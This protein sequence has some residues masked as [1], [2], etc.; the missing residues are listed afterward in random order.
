MT[1][2][3][4]LVIGNWKMNMLASQAKD[5]ARSL[6]D[7]FS[8]VEDVEVVIAPPYTSLY[9]VSRV[10]KDSPIGLAGQ[11]FYH[12]SNGAYTGEVALEM[13]TD[14]GCG[15][16][17][18]GHSERRSLF[19]END[20]TINKKVHRAIRLG[21]TAVVCVGETLEQ[22]HAEATLEVIGNQ[23]SK[24]LKGLSPDSISGLAVAYEP[25]WAIG[26]GVNA[27]PDQ[28]VEI[29]QFI[30]KFLFENLGF[31]ESIGVRILYGGSVTPENSRQLLKEK[32]IDGALV[33]GA[34]LNFESFCAII[35]SALEP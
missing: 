20:E 1:S 9:P 11:N 16:A 13:L 25:V 35:N 7:K 24:G 8:T 19:G 14:V 15:F 12:E 30:R 3:L 28:V 22:R 27:T 2:R 29:H 5:M 26:T 4:P 18:I 23:L 31:S 32:E 6:V 21:V 17:L 33:G 10:I 34:S